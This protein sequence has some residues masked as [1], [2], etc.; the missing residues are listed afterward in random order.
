VGFSPGGAYSSTAWVFGLGLEGDPNTALALKSISLRL[1]LATQALITLWF[2]YLRFIKGLTLDVR[3]LLALPLLLFFLT[4]YQHNA[5]Y[6]LLVAPALY[7]LLQTR[8]QLWILTVVMAMAWMP[9]ILYGLIGIQGTEAST[10]ETRKAILGEFV[11]PFIHLLPSFHILVVVLY[12]LALVGYV[13]W[14]IANTKKL[15]TL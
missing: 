6:L 1:T 3:L 11:G 10:H 7:L 14:L 15:A 12:T 2:L 9:R 8:W 13:L 4:L 5:E